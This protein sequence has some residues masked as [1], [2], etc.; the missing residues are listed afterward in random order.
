MFLHR[1]WGDS[2]HTDG[3]KLCLTEALQHKPA[4]T[5][6]LLNTHT[7]IGISVLPKG[8]KLVF[9]WCSREKV[10]E[11]LNYLKAKLLPSVSCGVKSVW[12]RGF[13][14]FLLKLF[15]FTDVD[16][17]VNFPLEFCLCVFL[18]FFFFKQS[19]VNPILFTYFIHY[20]SLIGNFVTCD[21]PVMTMG[22]P[23]RGSR[24]QSSTWGPTSRCGHR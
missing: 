12:H 9:P 23:I 6:P 24:Q 20:Y 3:G 16:P 22:R 1:L 8:T 7:H 2:F 15:L 14:T 21:H 19:G 5:D 10:S 17:G 18:F 4:P 13:R 11:R